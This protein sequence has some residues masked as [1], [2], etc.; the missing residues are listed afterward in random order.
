[1][2]NSHTGQTAAPPPV[3]RDAVHAT[4]ESGTTKEA[5]YR[6]VVLGCIFVAS[7][8]SVV[9]RIAWGNVSTFYAQA[10]GTSV[11][12]LG[13]FF[14]AFYI[15]YF[16]TNALSGFGADWFGGRRMLV[17]SML[18]L[19]AVTVGFSFT[20]SVA[21]G[22]VVQCAMGLVAG[23]D[24]SACVRLLSDVFPPERR[25][26]AMGLFLASI[27][28]GVALS[29]LF[30]PTL[31]KLVGW[32]DV[33]R[34]IGVLV[35]ATGVVVY[36]VLGP[37]SDRLARMSGAVGASPKALFGNRGFRIAAVA[38]FGQ[39]WG[40]WGF[41]FWSNALLIKGHHIDPVK[42]GF[43]IAVFG[44][45]TGAA[46]PVAG[47]IA[48]RVR[49]QKPILAALSCL[50][51]AISLAVFGG[52]DT[53]TAFT[54][55]SGLIGLFAGCAG[56]LVATLVVDTAGAQFSGTASGLANALWIIGNALVPL[57]VGGIFQYVHSFQAALLALAAG[58]A[59]ST[60]CFLHLARLGLAR[61]A[62][63]R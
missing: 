37:R 57:V 36:F 10:M 52:L 19:G 51:F 29:N 63:V 53:S 40:I 18:L 20:R 54:L 23:M 17:M 3:H 60:V 56:V 22:L 62:D 55:L 21:M 13:S 7:A 47:W 43:I 9:D 4:G 35:A 48:D 58:P 39:Q 59:F 45:L 16:V 1:M 61:R 44:V 49:I 27:P 31:I 41:A 2:L 26:T 25:T 24:Y 5:T 28:T 8:I 34:I 11:A 30:V 46:K 50:M 14:T 33:Y 6:W 15:G 32:E 12:A 42:A 38:G